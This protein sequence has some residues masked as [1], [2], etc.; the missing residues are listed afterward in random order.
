VVNGIPTFTRRLARVTGWFDNQLVDGAV[1][2]VAIVAGRAGEAARA[3]QTG[4]IRGYV[5]LLIGA[6]ALA[7]MAAVIVALAR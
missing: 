6:F 3:P 1:L 7:I 4:R 5:T 2:G